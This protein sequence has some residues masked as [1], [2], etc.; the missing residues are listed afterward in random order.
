[1]SLIKLKETIRELSVYIT[2]YLNY[3]VK[4]NTTRLP[5]VLFCNCK[6]EKENEVQ[7]F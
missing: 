5:L 3:N 6:K 2:A 1:M 7:F 4:I